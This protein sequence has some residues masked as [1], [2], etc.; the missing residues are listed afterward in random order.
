MVHTAVQKRLLNVR[1]V[2]LY[3]SQSEHT[4][5]AWIRKGRIP[6]SK[7][8]RSVRFD[9]HEIDKWLKRKQVISAVED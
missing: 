6:Y 5:R 2:A 7:L 8:E 3:L 9:L 4:I 1:D